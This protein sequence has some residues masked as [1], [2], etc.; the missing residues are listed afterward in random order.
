MIKL[1]IHTMKLSKRAMEQRL[2]KRA[3]IYGNRLG[4]MLGRSIKNNIF[5]F[6]KR[7]L[8]KRKNLH[9]V[10]FNLDKVYNRVPR[11]LIWRVVD[12]DSVSQG[13]IVTSL[14]SCMK[15]Q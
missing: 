6:W 11:E 15:G 9:M 10:F 3:K 13:V 12:K 7:T 14:K 1:I 4:F 8:R 5:S 2:G